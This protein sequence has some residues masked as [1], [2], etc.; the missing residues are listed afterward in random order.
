[1]RARI[2]K[3]DQVSDYNTSGTAGRLAGTLRRP[4]VAALVVCALLA[5]GVTTAVAAEPGSSGTTFHACLRQGTLTKVGTTPPACPLGSKA[6]SWNATGP[7][8]AR[9]P[10]GAR[11]PRGLQGIQGIQGVQ[12]PAGPSNSFFSS[13]T[14]LHIPSTLGTITV[15]VLLAGTY[16]VNADLSLEDTSG[17]N[18]SDLVECQLTLGSA[19]DAVD[20]GLL[21][22]SSAPENHGAMS[23]TVAATITATGLAAVKCVGAGNTGN[24]VVP[25]ATITAVQSGSLDVES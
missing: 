8:G 13:E 6:V 21:G 23:L 4:L 24:T 12:G 2:W 19:T 14:D 18:A 5:L 22:P 10:A 9:G 11:G 20:T 15:L 25:T 1:M 7:K 3:S 16:V 17:S